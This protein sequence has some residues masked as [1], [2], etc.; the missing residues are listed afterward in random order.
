MPPVHPRPC[1][2][3]C[4]QLV[5][6]KQNRTKYLPNH[7][8]AC[9]AGKLTAAKGGKAGTGHAKRRAQKTVPA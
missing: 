2:C 8:A 7:Y 1:L 6:A 5:T 9:A 3:G 4:G